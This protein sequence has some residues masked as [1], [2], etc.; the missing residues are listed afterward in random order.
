MEI[1]REP[2]SDLEGPRDGEPGL[3][4]MPTPGRGYKVGLDVPLRA[5][6]AGDADRTPSDEV[7]SLIADRLARD[8]PD[9]TGPTGADVCAWTYSPDGRFVVDRLDGG[10]VVLACG[11]SGEGFKFSALMGDV[12]ADLAEGRDVDEDVATWS[13]DRFDGSPAVPTLP[14]LGL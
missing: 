4:A 10:R 9:L 13:L 5:F 1:V 12:L 7:S 2:T 14:T 3:Y 8:L 6:D 11:D